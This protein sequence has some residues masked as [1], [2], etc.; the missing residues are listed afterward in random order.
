MATQRI[1]L[2]VGSGTVDPGYYGWNDP[3]PQG[4]LDDADGMATTLGAKGREYEAAVVA[5]PTIASLLAQLT[6]LAT[7]LGP[8]DELVLYYAGHGGRIPNQ[9]P[10]DRAGTVERPGHRRSGRA[11]ASD[12]FNVLCL[13][14]GLLLDLE[15]VN[16]WAQ[17]DPKARLIAVMDCCHA[18][19]AAT[20]VLPHEVERGLA[21]D[22]MP[23]AL[24]DEVI[25]RIA[26]R[27][28]DEL[29]RR[30]RVAAE[31]RRQYPSPLK[32]FVLTLGACRDDQLALA[33]RG[34]GE[35]TRV[36]RARLQRKTGAAT[37]AR[38]VT[39]LVRDLPQQRPTLTGFGTD[40]GIAT[41]VV[42]FTRTP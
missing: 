3:W 24:P 18:E 27:D 28:Q 17:C 37:Y 22:M 41:S 8:R 33:D 25:A 15:L 5:D 31:E 38:L 34:R 40:T 29:A 13:R 42:P 36:L 6:A 1:A 16:I 4:P 30:Q 2:C 32:G 26:R 21:G 39:E 23:R 20:K 35:F 7:Q 9:L 12:P 10:E 14:D 11:A 19:T